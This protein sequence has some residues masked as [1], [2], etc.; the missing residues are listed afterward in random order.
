MLGCIFSPTQ[1][2]PLLSNDWNNAAI[3]VFNLTGQMIVEKQNQNGKQFS[4]DLS[5][6]SAGIYFVEVQTA[7]GIYRSKVVKE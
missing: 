1:P 3:K 5:N 7:T 4:I 6:Q 2:I